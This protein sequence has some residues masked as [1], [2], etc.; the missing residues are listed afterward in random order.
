[1]NSPEINKDRMITIKTSEGERNVSSEDV[2]KAWSRVM[3]GKIPRDELIESLSKA[4]QKVR[5]APIE[6]LVSY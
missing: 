4:Y 1:M 2:D 3:Y 5:Y 6:K